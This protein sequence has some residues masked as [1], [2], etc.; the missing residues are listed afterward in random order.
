MLT[1]DDVRR[2][3]DL[4][5]QKLEEKLEQKLEEKLEQKLGDRQQQIERFVD[6]KLE[7]LETKLLTAFHGWASPV[8]ARIRAH[9]A[10][11]HALDLEQEAM[12]RRLDKL[13]G[14]APVT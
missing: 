9:A 6:Q 7:R 14:G 1:D 5:D 10:A 4:L 3:S 11:I 13:D 12:K 2:I 8:D